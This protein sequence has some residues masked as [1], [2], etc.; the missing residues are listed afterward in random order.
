[1]LSKAKILT[2][3]PRQAGRAGGT[4]YQKVW[5]LSSVLKGVSA[6]L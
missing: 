5:G 6:R 3:N 4:A 2:E 1:M